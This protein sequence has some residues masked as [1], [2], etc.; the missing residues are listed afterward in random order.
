[1]TPARDY[2]GIARAW[3]EDVVAGKIPAGRWIIAAAERFLRDIDRAA[4][5]WQYR[6]DA[7][8][9]AHLCAFN[10]ALPHIKGEAARHGGLLRLEP[11]QIFN[12][13]NLNGWRDVE[14]GRRRFRMSYTEV[15]RKNGKSTM[16]APDALFL[17]AADGEPGPEVYTAATKMDQARIV[18]NDAVEMARRTPALVGAAGLILQR[19]KILRPEVA[20]T[21]R[22]LEAK[23]LDGLNPHGVCVDELHEHRDRRVWDALA[24]GLGARG[25]P[26]MFAI[27]TAGENLDHV[28]YEQHDYVT[29]VLSGV[30][31]DESYF[32]MI[33]GIDPADDAFDETAWPKANPNLGV[34]KS[35]DYMRD[36]AK[37][38]MTAPAQRGEFLRKHLGVWTRAGA[39]AIDLDGWKRGRVEGL[40]RAAMAGAGGVLGLDLAL[41]EDMAAVA[42]VHEAPDGTWTVF[43]DH[44]ATQAAIEAPGRDALR[45][46]AARGLIEVHDG[47]QMDLDRIEDVAR[48]RAALFGAGEV[49][50]DPYLGGQMMARLSND[51]LPVVEMRQRPMDL[52]APFERLIAKISD[53]QV[54]HDGDPVL[55]WQISNVTER[56]RGAF[57]TPDHRTPNEKIDGPQAIITAAARLVAEPEPDTRSPWDADPNYRFEI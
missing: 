4:S 55:Q 29:K 32:G 19:H 17:F 39:T 52:S 14:T 51:G 12:K 41:R 22:P 1:M 7:D 8:D 31:D 42:W 30:Y 26:L 47:A 49:A 34:S 18:F 44:F 2:V 37:Q 28:C 15:A 21:M 5:G 46:F 40:T 13:V 16:A 23:K 48:E 3:A 56:K 6:L 38:A 24:D 50:I 9:A 57:R 43:C 10:E 53:G 36:R 35:L 54:R 20:G 45:G 11:W 25:N 27:T 33:F